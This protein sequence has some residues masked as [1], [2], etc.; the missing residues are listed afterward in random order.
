[1]GNSLILYDIDQSYSSSGRNV[2][3]IA[4]LLTGYYSHFKL[5][6]VKRSAQNPDIRE[7]SI[8]ILDNPHIVLNNNF[9]NQ[10]PN[11]KINFHYKLKDVKKHIL[12]SIL[13]PLREKD[14]SLFGKDC[15]VLIES[16]FLKGSYK[17]GEDLNELL[18]I[19][20][21][22]ELDEKNIGDTSNK[23]RYTSILKYKGFEKKN[24]Y[25]IISE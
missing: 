7:L 20:D 19:K 13:T 3:E 8:E 11:I 9:E 22:E 1:N 5:N 10:F 14:S 21:V 15:I 23:L 12:K 25:L 16:T 2:S 24:V 17:G 6:E 18:I 4:D